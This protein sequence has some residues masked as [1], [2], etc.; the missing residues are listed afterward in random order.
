MVN[1]LLIHPFKINLVKRNYFPKAAAVN[2]YIIN[3][4][5]K[6]SSFILILFG[7][8]NFFLRENIHI[9]WPGIEPAPWAGAPKRIKPA[10]FWCLGGCSNQLSH[11][12]L[13]TLHSRSLGWQ[14]DWLSLALLPS[15][16]GSLMRLQACIGS[17]KT[18]LTC[19]WLHL[20]H[21]P[22]CLREASPGFFTGKVQVS[23]REKELEGFWKPKLGSHFLHI[24]LAKARPLDDRSSQV[25]V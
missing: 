3:A 12:T 17:T 25:T 11:T 18:F 16:L 4:L 13:F 19:C 20:F 21:W 5:K 15:L 9:P 2:C 24:L 1:R 6:M 23:E 8:K 7:K 10:T 14:L 22:H